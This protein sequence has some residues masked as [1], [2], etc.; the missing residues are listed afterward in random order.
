MSDNENPEAETPTHVVTGMGPHTGDLTTRVIGDVSLLYR[1]RRVEPR[2]GYKV[3]RLSLVCDVLGFQ[4]T[5]DV[6]FTPGGGWQWNDSQEPVHFTC[7]NTNE[8]ALKASRLDSLRKILRANY[9]HF[10]AMAH[11]T[12]PEDTTGD[13]IRDEYA[14]QLFHIETGLLPE[15]AEEKYEEFYEALHDEYLASIEG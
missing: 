1:V 12:P 6:Y 9:F 4:P 13:A 8:L 7:G 2:N 15:R 10:E 14:K 5:A 3:A 11:S